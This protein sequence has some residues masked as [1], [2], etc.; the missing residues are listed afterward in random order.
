M[1]WILSEIVA[2]LLPSR[3]EFGRIGCRHLENIDLT[4]LPRTWLPFA[5][6]DDGDHS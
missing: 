1:S 5:G 2:G 6:C 4:P 3:D